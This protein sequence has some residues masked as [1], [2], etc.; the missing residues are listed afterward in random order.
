MV[1][2]K[3]AFNSLNR[4][5]ALWNVRVLWPRCSRFLF[6]FYRGWGCLISLRKCCNHG[7]MNSQSRS[8][9]DR[10]ATHVSDVHHDSASAHDLDSS[11]ND[12][13]GLESTSQDSSGV[14]NV[15]RSEEAR[16]L[17][18]DEVDNLM[19]DTYGESIYHSPLL[20]ES[21]SMWYSWW[22]DIHVQHNGNTMI[23]QEVLL[24]AN[25]FLK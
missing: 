6:N 14:S 10:G 16:Q 23:Y 20:D 4:V 25:M 15:F 1:D 3:N 12:L 18:R 7:T 19:F 17:S 5:A 24:G 9:S 2:A 22:R 11:N 8:V 21:Q 13:D